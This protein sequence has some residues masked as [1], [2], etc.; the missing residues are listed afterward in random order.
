VY[1]LLD[2]QS[3]VHTVSGS[4]AD[5]RRQDQCFSNSFP[6]PTRCNI[7]GIYACDTAL[8]MLLTYSIDFYNLTFL[9]LQFIYNTL[10]AL[11]G[12]N[13]AG[14]MDVCL[15]WVLCVVR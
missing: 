14:G 10:I 15:L 3:T 5:C 13:S 7:K 2:I 4:D 9:P 12:S 8:K 1:Y 11:W 6:S